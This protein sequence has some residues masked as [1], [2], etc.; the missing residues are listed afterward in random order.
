MESPRERDRTTTTFRSNRYRGRTMGRRFRKI[1]PYMWKKPAVRRLDR[2]TKLVWAYLLS[3]P[4]QVLCP[5][6]IVA[7]DIMIAEDLFS[8]PDADEIDPHEFARNLGNVQLSLGILLEKGFV[9]ID[10]EAR[11]IV[12]KRAV[13]HNLPDNPNIVRGWVSA[14]AEVPRCELRD[15]WV[16]LACAQLVEEFGA[17]DAKVRVLESAIAGEQ[18]ELPMMEPPAGED[19]DT[20]QGGD[21]AE[22]PE[23]EK[24]PA[25]VRESPHFDEAVRL[26]DFMASEIRRET[27]QWKEKFNRSKWIHQME[28][29]LRI[30]KRP[31]REVAE[32][33]RWAVSHEFWSSNIL[34]PS[35]L[36]KQY[37]TLIKQ[38]TRDK[39]TPQEGVESPNYKHGKSLRQE[40]TNAD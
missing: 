3:C 35:K 16:R 30:D 18:D 9:E 8:D 7:S 13:S 34:S 32:V 19:S 6:L 21:P 40:V 31:A 27:P 22:D 12:V 4:Y 39:R 10:R 38:R 2:D 23:I 28:A 11:V 25:T 14:L 17:R 5:G 37:V 29:I 20:G 1:E 36:R 15:R 24:L 33:I 26:V